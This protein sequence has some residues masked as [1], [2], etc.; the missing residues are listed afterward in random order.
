MLSNPGKKRELK[1]IVFGLSSSCKENNDEIIADQPPVKKIALMPNSFL[2]VKPCATSGAKPVSAL[3]SLMK[4][5][6]AKKKTLFAKEEKECR[7]EYWLHP[8]IV[9]KIMNKKLADGK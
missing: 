4:E 1:P 8:G 5:E 9:V 3:E 7:K 6:E 2:A